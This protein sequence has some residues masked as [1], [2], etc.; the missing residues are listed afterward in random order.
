MV[1]TLRPLRLKRT[2]RQSG[3]V[4]K[5]ILCK[6]CLPLQNDLYRFLVLNIM[7][8]VFSISMVVL[9]LTVMLHLTVA[10]HYCGGELAGSTVSLSG[11]LAS[12]GMENTEKDKK[13][14]GCFLNNHCCDDVVTFYIIASNYTSSFSVVSHFKKYNL[15]VFNIPVG[16]SVQ[17]SYVLTSLN[18]N[19][20]PPDELM[21]TS[22]DLSDICVFRI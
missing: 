1:L 15:L 18:T 9:V 21:S 4:C 20:S 14:S 16:L 11:K 10:T 19:I 5:T 7:K 2:F 12:C 22:V 3:F 8:K 17:S 6:K 13:L